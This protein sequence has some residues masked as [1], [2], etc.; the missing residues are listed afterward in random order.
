MILK[1]VLNVQLIEMNIVYGL[2]GAGFVLMLLFSVNWK[3]IGDILNFPFGALGGFVDILSYIRLFAVGLSGLYVAKSINAMGA[4]LFG[5]GVFGMVGGSIVILVGHFI[6][7]ALCA[8]GV[9]V[10]G[11]RLNTLEFSGHLGLEWSGIAFKPFRRRSK[12][13]N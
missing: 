1:M 11:I 8:M 12:Q 10:H 4:G 3:D 5:M 9:L 6:N 13:V 2:L 7:V